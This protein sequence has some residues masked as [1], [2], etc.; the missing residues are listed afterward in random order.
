MFIFKHKFT[1]VKNDFVLLHFFKKVSTACIMIAKKHIL[2]SPN[3][4]QSLLKGLY[5]SN[6][7]AVKH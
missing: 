4:F 2:L 5:Y 6:V 3:M 1:A 7:Q